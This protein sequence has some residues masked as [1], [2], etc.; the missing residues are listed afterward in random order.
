M[1]ASWLTIPKTF[2]EVSSAGKKMGT[3]FWN[4][5]GVSIVDYFEESRTINDVQLTLAISN[6]LISNNR[7]SRS[8]HLVPA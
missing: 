5:Q 1:E 2:H 8:K 6:S 4:S 7:L 3:V